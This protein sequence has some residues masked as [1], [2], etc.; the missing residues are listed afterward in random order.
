MKFYFFILFLSASLLAQAQNPLLTIVLMVKN[1]AHVMEET[2]Q[3]FVDAGLDRFLIFDTG[4]TDDTISI[5]KHFFEKHNVCNGVILQEP[6]VDF[7]TSRNRAL[8][9]AENTFPDGHFMLMLDAEWYIHNVDDLLTFCEQHKHDSCS[10]YLVRIMSTHL[11]FYTARLIRCKTNIRFFGVVHET[12]NHCTRQKVPQNIFFELKTTRYG[13]EKSK[14]RWVRDCQLLLDEYER[15]PNNARTVFYLAQTYACL[16][17]WENACKW[18]TLRTTMDGW[19]EENYMA[20]YK[21][22]RAYEKAGDWEKALFYYLEAAKKRPHRAEPLIRLAQHY[23]DTGDKELCYLFAQ[24][25]AELPYPQSDILFVEKKL[26]QFTR[27]DLLGRS[28]WYVGKYSLGK[29]SIEKALTIYPDLEYLKNNLT[30][31]KK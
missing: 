5:T 11:D 13:K 29:K 30:F 21:L 31:Y 28:A 1:E 15:N 7:A 10:A 2:L 25:A 26:Y 17:D 3:P 24:R 9:L 19:E 22:A 20:L 4:S 12:L 27:H 8:E 18:Y 14:K 16:G 6:F 23:W